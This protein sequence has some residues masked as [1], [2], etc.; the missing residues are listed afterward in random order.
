[1]LLMTVK[2]TVCFQELAGGPPSDATGAFLQKVA[3]DH[4]CVGGFAGNMAQ[5]H[6]QENALDGPAGALTP[7]E[8][9]R[10]SKG[11]SIEHP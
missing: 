1:M 3:A 2:C 6:A 8:I 4:Q 7:E 9:D 11:G 5:L 10:L